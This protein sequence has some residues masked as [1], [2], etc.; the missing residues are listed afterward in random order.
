MSSTPACAP[1]SEASSTPRRSFSSLRGVRWRIHLGV[2]PTS[3]TASIDD[4]R[5]VTADTRRRYATLRRRLLLDHHPPKDGDASRDLTID[6]P[7]S[8]NPESTWGRFFKNAELEKTVEQDL[9][10]L[11]PELDD[12]FHTPLFQAMLRRILLLWC[13]Q[14]PEYG[15]RQGMHELLA[16]LLYVLHVDINRFFQLQKLH[17]DCLDEEFDG[18]SFSKNDL[19]DYGN[20]NVR[21]WDSGIE[22]T[23]GLDGM[24]NDHSINE[25][26]PETRD[27]LL[28]CDPYGAE[29]EL[30]VIVSKRFM[31]HD[32]YCMFENLMDG[33]QGVVGLASF[34]SPVVGSDTNKPP[35]IE[36]SSALY[37]LL[38]LVDSSLHSH[39]VELGVEPQYFALRWLRCLYGREFCLDDLLIIWDEVFSFSNSRFIG[40]DMQYNF[41]VLCSPRG[42]FITALAVSMLLYLRSS[43][44]AT[45]TAT[46]CL[47]RLLCFPQNPDM[48]KLIEKAKSLQALV[49]ESNIFSPLSERE[50]KKNKLAVRRFNLPSGSALPMTLPNIVPDSYWEKK[51]LVLHKD[52]EPKMQNSDSS[53]SVMTKILTEKLSLSRTK[54]EPLEPEIARAQSPI[55]RQHFNET[56]AVIENVQSSYQVEEPK[57]QNSDSSSSVMTKILTEKLSLSR[58]KSEPFEPEIARAQSPISRQHFNETSAVIENVQG[59]YQVEEPKMQNSDSSSSVMTK[60][61]TEKLSLSRT[62]SEPLEPEIA[63]A[64]SPISRQHFNEASAVI[65]NVQGSYQVDKLPMILNVNATKDSPVE[66]EDESTYNCSAD[67][68]ILSDDDTSVLPIST[69]PHDHENELEKS[70]S[71]T[72]SLIGD[73]NEDTINLEEHSGQNIKS[74]F[75][76]EAETTSAVDGSTEEKS[77]AAPNGWRSL[78]GKLQWLWKFGRVS[79]KENQGSR[80]FCTTGDAKKNNLDNEITDETNYFGINKRIERDTKVMDALK[81]LGQS[82]LDNIQVIESVFQQERIKFDTFENL[83]NNILGS[84]GQTATVS[85]L[86][87]L[88]KISN[89]LQEM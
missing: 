89:L 83:S 44:L 57:I 46:T 8:Q 88:R 41:K 39:L 81:S 65:E 43:L 79:N 22:A 77:L 47:Q 7:L 55:S 75:A 72:S 40:D 2:L 49:L 78:E 27:V 73:D 20:R 87:E 11:Y 34:Y 61:L 74:Q 51:W 48:R 68:T 66:L 14:H 56:S 42:A 36:A 19:F 82:M 10:R 60:I 62:K 30:G 31:E 9:S 29:G 84:K 23:N 21:N 33:A 54:S 32:A 28:L 16:P 24:S 17:K 6:N 67:E 38:S 70:S 37:H 26:D 1:S 18:I 53:S 5:R 71:T 85:A 69:Y 3:P 13:L 58:T 45:E 86:K 59:S 63:R 4:L 15:Y 12:Y 76:Q 80:P 64:Q 50:L 52:E 35:V 25:L